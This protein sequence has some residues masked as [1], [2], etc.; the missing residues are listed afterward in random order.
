VWSSLGGASGRATFHT[1][2][3]TAELAAGGGV[4]R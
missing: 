4:T 3:V 1:G 2:K